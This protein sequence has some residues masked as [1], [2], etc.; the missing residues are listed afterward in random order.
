MVYS[1]RA[2]WRVRAASSAFHA[3][4]R[5]PANLT[6]GADGA[7][8]GRAV[9]VV[10]TSLSSEDGN[11]WAIQA[12]S[13]RALRFC[14]VM[15]MRRIRLSTRRSSPGLASPVTRRYASSPAVPPT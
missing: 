15:P 13:L 2:S 12:A 14:T 1:A 8:T 3:R 9:L 6:S 7:P 11:A 4:V 10:D 5:L